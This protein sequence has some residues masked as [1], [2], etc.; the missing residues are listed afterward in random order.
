MAAAMVV[1]AP[2]AHPLTRCAW[3]GAA[4]A[5]LDRE[6]F[7]ACG[8]EDRGE[9]PAR[10]G[11]D[12]GT[13][14]SRRVATPCPHQQLLRGLDAAPSELT[15]MAVMMATGREHE[16]GDGSGDCKDVTMKGGSHCS[17]GGRVLRGRRGRW[18]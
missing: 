7:D 3:A 4:L 5:A 13:G 17:L 12:A 2:W 16:D 6:G 15:V 9:R 10:G 8:E 14:G 1:L 11:N 18:W